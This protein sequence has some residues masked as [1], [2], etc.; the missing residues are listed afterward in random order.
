M[1]DQHTEYLLN[2]K[3]TLERLL[4]SISLRID[5]SLSID[6]AQVLKRQ[7]RFV[8][9]ISD[10]LAKLDPT[11]VTN[12]RPLFAQSAY[13][14]AFL[15]DRANPDGPLAPGQLEL[16]ETAVRYDPT[17]AEYQQLLA[18]LRER[19]PPPPQ[20][21]RPQSLKPGVKPR[22]IGYL[23]KCT[24][25]R[26]DYLMGT[27]E[28][29]C[30]V[31][32]CISTAPGGQPMRGMG[33]H[34]SESLALSDAEQAGHR[35]ADLYAYRLLPAAFGEDGEMLDLDEEER[36]ALA[37]AEENVEPIPPDYVF[38]GW[39]IT[40][41]SLGWKDWPRFECSPLTCNGLANEV[42]TNRYGLIHE[43][44]R[45]LA[46]VPRII[47]GPSE[48]GTYYLVQVWRKARNNESN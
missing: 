32:C 9:H 26:Q 8:R 19:A 45:A 34:A 38:L 3:K 13:Y 27:V 24:Q 10:Q 30:S 28:E 16:A 39:D 18:R 6:E 48:P 44:D 31:S 43:L 41:N 33:F 14:A 46:L 29:V 12:C 25:G 23:V 4:G 36:D 42:M 15:A 22:P 5:A 20:A 17:V 7:L 2:C 47:E 40:T 37:A 1:L 35:S 21:Q 11:D